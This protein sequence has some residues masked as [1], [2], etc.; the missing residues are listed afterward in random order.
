MERFVTVLLTVNL[1]SLIVAFVTIR[2]NGSGQG[3]ATVDTKILI[4]HCIKNEV[5]QRFTQ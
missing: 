4:S 2:K 1:Q 3:M 5:F